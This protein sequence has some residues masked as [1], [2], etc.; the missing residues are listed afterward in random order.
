[1]KKLLFILAF[2]GLMTSCGD[3]DSGS[4][5]KVPTNITVTSADPSFAGTYAF[6]Y[7]NKNRLTQLT[8]TG[9]QNYSLA[10][11]YGNKNRPQTITASGDQD[12]V[13]NLTYDNKNRVVTAVSQYSALTLTYN[14]D[15]FTVNGISGSLTSNS[16]LASLSTLQLSYDNSKKG[17]FANVKGVDGFLMALI[18][19]NA[20][21]FATKKAI[22][23]L[24]NPDA[25]NPTTTVTHTFDGGLPVST[26]VSGSANLTMAITYN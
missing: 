8:K 21:Y 18:E 7:D 19:S 12:A 14:G 25:A 20:P 17:A 10:F 16:D 9:A 5:G 15:N 26:Q 4:K 2:A 22:S 1:M 23:G 6:S 13:I 11:D 24:V 3:D